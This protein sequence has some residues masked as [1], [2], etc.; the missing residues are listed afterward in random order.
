M[1]L[2]LETPRRRLAPSRST[3]ADILIEL[4][5]DPEVLRF[6]GLRMSEA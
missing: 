1:N 2:I 5:T 3:D 4:F 6:A